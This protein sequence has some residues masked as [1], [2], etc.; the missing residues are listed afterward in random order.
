MELRAQSLTSNPIPNALDE[1]GTGQNPSMLI[2]PKFYK[3]D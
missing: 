2:S 3:T 1:E